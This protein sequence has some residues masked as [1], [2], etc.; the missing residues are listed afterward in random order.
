MYH[1]LYTCLKRD[2]VTLRIKLLFK[3]VDVVE[4]STRWSKAKMVL[5]CNNGVGSNPVEQ[6]F[7]S[8]KI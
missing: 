2:K 6:K 7:D 3:G 5:Q 1:R 4:W 8:S